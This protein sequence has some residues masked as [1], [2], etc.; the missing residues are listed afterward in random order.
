MFDQVKRT[1]S[2][3]RFCR[4]FGLRRRRKPVGPRTQL[5][6]QRCLKRLKFPRC[7][8]PRPAARE[9]DDLE[10]VNVPHRF[11]TVAFRPCQDPERILRPHNIFPIRSITFQSS[12]GKVFRF[13]SFELSF[14]LF[15][16]NNLS[17]NRVSLN[18]KTDKT[19]V[20]GSLLM[21]LVLDVETYIF[22]KHVS[23]ISKNL[24][25]TIQSCFDQS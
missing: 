23:A 1:N 6:F 7:H 5:S 3:G 16:L 10:S 22:R 2:I 21:K 14:K 8:S 24:H 12:Q 4:A 13:E 9:L 19:V 20:R 11:A 18:K 15:L 25:R 17:L